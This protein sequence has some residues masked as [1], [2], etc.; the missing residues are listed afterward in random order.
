MTYPPPGGPM[1]PGFGGPAQPNPA[2]AAAARR[3]KRR[4]TL[5]LSAIVAVLALIVGLGALKLY[6]DK[7]GKDLFPTLT[8][9]SADDAG[10]DPFTPSVALTNRT[11]PMQNQVPTASEL[12]VR[13]V[14][15][16]APG[17]YA[18]TGEAI[19]DTAKLGNDLAANPAAGRAWASVFGINA[20]DIPWYLNTLTP[21]VLTADTWVTNY[22]FR[23][24]TASPF[25]SVLQAGTPVYVDAAGVPRAVCACGNPLRPPSAAPV[26]GYRVTGH[27]WNTYN[28]Q[29]V[30]RIT[31]NN[32]YVTNV[33]NTT[34]I[35][36]NPAPAPA[37]NAPLQLINIV[38]GVLDSV[39]VGGTLELP[40]PPPEVELPDPFA[41]NA[42]PTFADA[43]D[44][45]RQG[46]E[47]GT[48]QPAPAMVER[49]AA[50]NGVPPIVLPG[51]SGQPESTVSSDANAPVPG[52]PGAPDASET[53]G[54][55]NVPAPS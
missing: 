36:N 11:V 7:T 39:S 16:T 12:G 54:V 26:G 32:R 55:P 5:I 31:T 13:L 43:A 23:S 41:S 46:L 28:T 42:A 38:T 18:N 50:N 20:S 40:P 2:A 4:L 37:P 27:P 52:A 3:S 15:G 25:Q 45:E 49:N 14:N 21:V 34:T 44:A 6:S 19:C 8:L 24:G 9:R 30:T 35:I 10:P 17:L 29:N 22:A 33:N 1:Y 53:S 51:I 48:D 47:P